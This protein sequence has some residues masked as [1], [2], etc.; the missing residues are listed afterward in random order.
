[1]KKIITVSCLLITLLTNA[2]VFTGTGGSILNNGQDSYFPINVTGLNPTSIDSVF[3]IEQICFTITHAD[4][5]E[6]YIYLKSPAGII[7]ELTLGNSSAGANFSNTCFENQTGNSITLGT[8][9]YT[10]NYKPVGYLGRFNTGQTGNGVWNLIVHDGFPSTNA[11]TLVSWNI[12]FGNTPAH[13]VIL[14]SSNLPLVF[15]NTTQP[16]T[17]NNSPADIGI[18]YNGSGRNNLTDTRN[19][20]NNKAQINIRGN[21]SKNFEKK[22]FSIETHDATGKELDAPLVGMPAESDWVL[23]ASYIDKTLIRNPLTFDLYRLMGHYSSRYKNVEVFLNNEY[24]GIY[25][26]AEKPKRNINRINIEKLDK[27]ENTQPYVSGGYIFKIDRPIEPGWYSHLAGN[28]PANSKFYYQYVYP[29]DS[30]IT[31]SQKTY[32]QTYMNDFETMMSSATYADPVNG[33]PKYID[34]DSFVDLFIINELSKN[35]D[36]YRL[37]TYMYKKSI[38][39]GGKLSVGPVWDYDIA[40]HNCNYNNSF[41]SSGWAYQL[42]DNSYPVPKWWSRLMDDANFADKVKCRWSSLRQNILSTSY[43]NNYIDVS[44]AALSEAQQRNFRQWPIIGAYI[45]PNPQNQAGASYATEIADLKS[46]IA[47]RAAWIDANLPGNC[48]VGLQEH[49]VNNKLLV[50]P[51]PMESQTTFSMKLEKESDISLCIT[52]LVGKEVTR[53]L[54][55]NVPPGDS[56]IVLERNQMQSGIYLYQLEINNTVTTGKIIVQ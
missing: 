37:S 46:W 27:T 53:F 6:L 7:V 30:D 47:S 44:A 28:C 39:E 50:Y 13:P 12:K 52:D 20:Y 3:G 54:N 18:V 5:S 24:Q 1:M 38:I 40:W 9:P 16:I 8:S 32:I 11:G 15:I 26:L 45:N 10:G 2:Q 31:A 33:Y 41:I 4:V 22:S 49:F 17:D 34:I 19:N 29:N 55:T 56:K 51:N 23:I 43:L 25:A 21:T 14:N 35:I 42:Q 48:V 36:G